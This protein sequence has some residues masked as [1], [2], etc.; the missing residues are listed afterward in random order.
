M[1]T[2]HRC[3][4]IG[5]GAWGT[6]LADLLATNGYEVALWCFE[7]SVCESICCQGINHVYLPDHKLHPG[8]RAT[9]DLR[10]CVAD[11]D[12]VVVATPS[13]HVRA[14]AEQI[15]HSIAQ[16]TFLVSATKGIENGTQMTMSQVYSDVFQHNFQSRFG[17]LSGPS[18]AAEV[19]AQKPTAVT[20]A[21]WD[22]R[23]AAKLQQVFSSA[24]FRCYT[25][26]DVIGVELGGSLKN[27]VAIAVGAL[28]GMQVGHN[29]RAGLI[30][31]ALSQIARIGIPLGANPLT[32]SGLS[33]AGDLILTCTSSQSRN[34]TF[35]Y[36]LGK[37]ESISDILH[38]QPQVV[39]GYL[40]SKSVYRLIQQLGLRASIFEQL[41]LF[42]H[43]N[44]AN[45]PISHFIDIVMS[46]QLK[47]ELPWF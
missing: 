34:R 5:A 39:E 7:N 9:S 23:T 16:H 28:D 36:R 27:V 41:Y 47:S 4:V 24:Y 37:G 42:L 30:T 19:A 15:S 43:E 38:A 31:R 20:V 25:S 33:G 45:H 18:F 10:R 46:Q 8:V 3:A 11:K 32:L 29:A 6:A 26:T 1:N 13:H 35:G 21:S 12:L 14:I 40:T 44:E 17:V 22:Y 2:L